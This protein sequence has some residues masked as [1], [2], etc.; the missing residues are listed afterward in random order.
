MPHLQFETNF[1]A[2]VDEKKQFAA[3]VIR[4]FSEI[5]DTGTDHIAVTLQCFAAEDLTFGRAGPS[6]WDEP[7][8]RSGASPSRSSTSSRRPGASLE[9]RCT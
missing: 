8:I 5:M 2:T 4:H 6:A 7:R 3:A 1:S 9:K